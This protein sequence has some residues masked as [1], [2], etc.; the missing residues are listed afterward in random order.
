MP[1][2]SAYSASK[3]AA[4]RLF[5]HFSVEHPGIRVIHYHPGLY[6]TD[7]GT[8]TEEA[9]LGLLFDDISLAGGFAVWAAS[10]E[11][12]FLHNRFV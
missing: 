6:R 7:S 4:V 5:E 2:Y 11:A 3:L 1:G 9:G 12:A 10:P 8:T